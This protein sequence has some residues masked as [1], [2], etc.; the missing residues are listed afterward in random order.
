MA[1]QKPWIDHKWWQPTSDLTVYANDGWA[2]LNDD[3]SHRWRYI[4]NLQGEMEWTFVLRDMQETAELWLE[5]WQDEM[6]SGWLMLRTPTSTATL[7]LSEDDCKALS[8]SVRELMTRHS[9]GI[10]AP[11]ERTITQLGKYPQSF[12]GTE[13]IFTSPKVFS[14]K[15]SEDN[16]VGDL[17]PSENIEIAPWLAH[18]LRD[19]K[20]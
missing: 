2:V 4:T 15:W 5:S 7:N 6:P 20:D 16:S 14:H 10:S 18:L 17:D 3:G 19:S 8:Q 1:Q 9:E 13:Q 12:T 11:Q